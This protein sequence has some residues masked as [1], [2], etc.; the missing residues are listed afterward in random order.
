MWPSTYQGINTDVWT[1]KLPYNPWDEWYFLVFV[2]AQLWY[3]LHTIHN[4]HLAEAHRFLRQI[5]IYSLIDPSDT[6][7]KCLK[8]TAEGASW[9]EFRNPQKCLVTQSVHTLQY[10]QISNRSKHQNSSWIHNLCSF[11]IQYLIQTSRAMKRCHTY[12]MLN[13]DKVGCCKKA[14]YCHFG[15]AFCIFC[16][17]VIDTSLC[18][19]LWV[20]RFINMFWESF[21]CFIWPFDNRLESS[22]SVYRRNSNYWAALGE[23]ASVCTPGSRKSACVPNEKLK[24]V[25]NR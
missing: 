16:K 7:S 20:I 6:P 10:L 14:W 24:D 9:Y 11:I 2:L 21:R 18:A 17:M 15:R 13:P 1:R 5:H 23:K 12:A 3:E 22:R 25:G 8:V 19:Y 4:L